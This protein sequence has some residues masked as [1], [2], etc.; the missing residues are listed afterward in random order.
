MST[1]I[2]V[3]EPTEDKNTKIELVELLTH[4]EQVFT[5]PQIEA[6]M[7]FWYGYTPKQIVDELNIAGDQLQF[8]LGDRLFL[9]AIQAGKNRRKEMVADELEKMSLKALQVVKEV[10]DLE[11][12]PSTRG[13]KDIV[14]TA[15]WVVDKNIV[16]VDNGEDNSEKSYSKIEPETLKILADHLKTHNPDEKGVTIE[17]LVLSDVVEGKVTSLAEYYNLVSSKDSVLA[18]YGVI[19]V[20]IPS[21]VD[22]N[23]QLIQHSTNVEEAKMQCH[24]CGKWMAGLKLHITKSHADMGIINYRRHFGIPD[25]LPMS[26]DDSFYEMIEEKLEQ[27]RKYG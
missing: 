11:L 7:M 23:G 8:W 2:V 12:D 20:H 6:L 21:E 3:R 1:S 14:A 10:L 16:R 5:F 4:Y 26:V 27:F 25:G 15:K 9:E 22:S 17:S 19:N 24:I 18:N 13:F